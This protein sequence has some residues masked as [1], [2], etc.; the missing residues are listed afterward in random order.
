MMTQ[1][2]VTKPRTLFT[3]A[4]REALHALRLQY[5]Q[6]HDLFSTGERMR[7]RFVRW[8]RQTGRI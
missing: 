6:D 2:K 7:L 5:Q 4:E 3:A 1:P 8:L